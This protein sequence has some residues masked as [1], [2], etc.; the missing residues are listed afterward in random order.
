[1]NIIKYRK[2]WLSISIAMVFISVP[3]IF[4]FRPVPG[5]DF[6]GGTLIEIKPNTTVSIGQVREKIQTFLPKRALIIQE[7]GE[8]QYVIRTSNLD[9]N[10]YKD[11]ENK[12]NDALG[13]P[14]ILRHEAIGGSVGQATTR[15]AIYAILVAGVLIICYLAAAF[16][17]VPKSVSPWAF[18]TIAFVTLIH[19]LSFSFAVFS[20]VSRF[21]GYEL[22]STI[23]VAAL[24]I[25]GF[26]VHD[27]IV[28][29]DRIRENIIKN[30]QRNFAENCEIS[31]NQT[32][33]RSLNT[34]LA[35][36]LVLIS[37]LLL[38]G[39]TIKP[40]ILMLTLGIAIGTYSSIFVASPILVFYHSYINRKSQKNS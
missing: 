10:E 36:I 31:I 37:M 20:V 23:L 19:D 38:G 18:G 21:K 32:I 34:S 26:S 13:N 3:L 11:F 12:L 5:I 2:I 1:M 25:L 33:A 8:N 30:P 7:S 17:K 22:D 28:V 16:R 35:A 15:N 29:F 6:T 27:T 4:I 9:A 40:F 39:S 14:N 24:T